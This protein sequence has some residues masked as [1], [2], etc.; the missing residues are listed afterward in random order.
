MKNKLYIML[1][2]MLMTGIHNIT[3]AQTS[4]KS[5]MQPMW[6]PAGYHQ[7]DYYYLPDIEAYYSVTSHQFIF[8]SNGRWLY[9]STLP[10][11]F[12]NYDLY[13]GYKVVINKPRPFLNFSEDRQLYAK[14]K[15]QKGK[16]I[17]IRDGAN[18]NSHILQSGPGKKRDTRPDYGP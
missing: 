6:G 15:N 11:Q 8:L 12:K 10:K 4:A 5:T 9:S 14:F 17:L 13:S 2:I 7:A 16:Q 18:V 3:Y 1:I